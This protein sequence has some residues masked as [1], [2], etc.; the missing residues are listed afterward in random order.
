[1]TNYPWVARR[2]PSRA[3]VLGTAGYLMLWVAIFNGYPTV[4][5]DTGEYL[6]ISFTPW[7]SP[8]RSIIYSLSI[9]G[10]VRETNVSSIC[11]FQT[12]SRQLSV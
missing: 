12:R 8:Y 1:M 7:Q 3:F 11:H 2:S 5:D 4:Y 6:S 9:R 10:G